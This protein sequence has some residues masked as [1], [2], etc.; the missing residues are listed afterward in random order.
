MRRKAAPEG[1]AL[2]MCSMWEAGLECGRGV[3]YSLL[4]LC[5]PAL[6]TTPPCPQVIDFACT[7]EEMEALGCE[8]S[9][10]CPQT[11]VF[12]GSI[13]PQPPSLH[14]CSLSKV[15]SFMRAVKVSLLVVDLAPAP[16]PIPVFHSGPHSWHRH[17]LQTY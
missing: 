17:S 8:L 10:S 9:T 6:P 7:L 15:H 4:D 16:S 3:C 5:S 11:P 12:S 14:P 13:Q 2:G 1:S